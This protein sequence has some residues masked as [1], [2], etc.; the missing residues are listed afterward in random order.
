MP[1]ELMC[2][3]ASIALGALLNLNVALLLALELP[4]IA[5]YRLLA[6]HQGS[7]LGSWETIVELYGIH[8]IGW[9]TH[10]IGDFWD[11]LGGM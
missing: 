11:G 5:L 6:V 8:S 4:K 2:G 7:W 10:V 9:T 1:S 3:S